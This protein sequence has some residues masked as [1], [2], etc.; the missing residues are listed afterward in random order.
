[1]YTIVTHEDRAALVQSTETQ[2]L[3]V[4]GGTLKNRQI[5][6]D[7]LSF[8]SNQQEKMPSNF[9]IDAIYMKYF[10][11]IHFTKEICKTYEKT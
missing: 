10:T 6:F 2:R 4:R 8:M 9:Y 3:E 1:M 7:A 11:F 5:M